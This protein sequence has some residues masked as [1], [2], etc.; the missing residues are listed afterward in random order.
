MLLYL[1]RHG[2]SAFNA[3]QRIQGQLD[4]PLSPL[5]ERQSRALAA[6]FRALPPLDALYASPLRRALDTARPIAAALGLD[7]QLDP[8]LM[9]IHA[10]V[11]Q[12]LIWPEIER[13]FPAE[14]VAWRSQDPDYRLPEGESR[15]DLMQRA[16]TA[17]E[18]I[19]ATGHARVGIVAH[20]G[21]LSAGLKSLLEIPPRRNP[22]VLYNGSINVL[23]WADQVKVI[24]LNQMDHLRAGG[25]DLRSRT[26]DL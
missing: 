13:R 18:T 5:G 1:V 6:A 3:E 15:A 2:E 16:Q 14:A 20:G 24:V 17:L 19:R 23:E 22:F 26:G 10:G 7:L 11:F 12:G 8:R 4:I 9:E 21:V 25:D